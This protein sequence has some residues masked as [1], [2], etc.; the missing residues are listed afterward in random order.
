MYSGNLSLVVQMHLDS[1][2]CISLRVCTG[3]AVASRDATEQ[4]S[5]AL[6]VDKQ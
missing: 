4:L 3:I 5:V 1:S 2:G 6:N